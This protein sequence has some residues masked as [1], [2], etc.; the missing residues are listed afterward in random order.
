MKP[1]PSE[2]SLDPYEEILALIET[3]H[4][5][6]QRVEE[7]TAGQIDTVTNRTGQTFV[8]RPAQEHLRQI[9]AT[10]QAAI[11]NSLPA[12]VALLD[13]QGFIVSVND[14]WRA[15]ADANAVLTPRY[16]IGIS[17]LSVCDRA[18][19]DGSLLA[20]RAAAGIRSVLNGESKRYSVEY[21]CHSPDQERWFLMIVTPIA[22]KVPAGAVV[23][24]VDITERWK[25]TLELRE[26]ERRFSDF[27]QNVELL[28]V[29]LD[30]NARITF[31]NDYLLRLTGWLNEEVLG[32]SWFEVFSPPD[33]IQS[34]SA[35][36]TLLAGT[37]EV[38]HHES[39]ILTRSGD[40]RLIRWSNSALKS[41]SGEL[42]GTASIGEDVT[43]QRQASAE[44]L[45]SRQRLALATE[46][47]SLGIWDFDATT[48]TMAWDAQMLT[49]YGIGEQNADD[50]YDVWQ[51]GL[52]PE[53]R[54][55]VNADF[56]AALAGS[57]D[58][59]PQ[60]RVVWPNGEIR[61]LEARAVVQRSA[62]GVAT[63]MTG[64][65][66]DITERIRADRRIKQLNRVYA[67]L[68]G[69]NTL[70]VRVRTREELFEGACRI[71]VEQGEFR[72]ALLGILDADKTKIE[73]VAVVCADDELTTSITQLLSESH[74]AL[75]AMT[76]QAVEQKKP[77]VSNDSQHDSNVTG[78]DRHARFGVRSM[79]VLPVVVAGDAVGAMALYS[80]EL[81][82]F[83]AEELSLLTELAGDIAYAMDHVDKQDRLQYQAYY[84][85]LTGL[86]NRSMFLERVA[87]YTRD[88]SGDGN[89]VAVCLFDLE[90][91][92]N[93]NDDLGR[94]AGD[95][96]LIQVADWL[97]QSVRDA[98]VVARMDADRFAIA[99][100]RVPSKNLLV[101]ILQQ[102]REMFLLHPFHIDGGLFRIAF[103]GG[104]ALFPDDGTD[105][106][107]LLAHAEVALDKAKS[108]GEPY[109]FYEK[110]M[111]HAAAD[112]PTLEHQL[113]H[114]LDNGEF[115]LHY[116]PKVS[117]GTGKLTGVEGLIRWN[118]PEAGLIAP[119]R[120]IPILEETGLIH[121]VGQWVLNKAIDDF[122][123]W[124]RTGLTAVPIAV[125]ISPLQLRHRG[126]LELIQSSIAV[127]AG[128]AAGL[129]LEITESL[130]M[131]NV[132][133]SIESLH[134]IRAMG[135]RVA[136]DD[137]GT[138]FSSLSYLSRLPIDTL[139]ID[140]SFVNSMTTG[141]QGL[142]LVSTIVSLARSLSLKV[143]A[144]GVETDEEFRLLRLLGCDEMQGYLFSEPLPCEVLEERYLSK[145]AAAFTRLGAGT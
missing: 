91:F 99:L 14:A 120:F 61:N 143:V 90:R 42:I 118:D 135:V 97:R 27:L 138:G 96:V 82:F 109:L 8:L 18:R 76:A 26:S 38:W 131:E 5:T 121:H 133:H 94:H 124:Q 47:A 142:A 87:Q 129:E 110:Q 71:A 79:I 114:A 103:K 113:R 136:I 55:F 45:Q 68:S 78:G 98:G 59:D 132:N 12:H 126:F 35:I 123:R 64:V 25:S 70:I 107:M 128:A 134:A 102:Q 81:D 95:N 10:K 105:A 29:M 21:G 57:K 119:A 40:S 6:E 4:R 16:E 125:N 46:S 69:I 33:T 28:S 89:L 85:A 127:D 112:R 93:I 72:I 80:S 3:L 141:R 86:A 13:A 50:T 32:R 139:K 37:P 117:L 108:S 52:H 9:E 1:D 19:A 23:M 67:V 116:Q 140:R 58:F 62:D 73:P 7:L 144:E 17:Y 74:G 54:D 115:V 88:D 2:P 51:R 75:T 48:R 60:F 56:A 83:Q 77:V 20:G 130:I 44:V 137:F 31:C 100:P 30:T 11:L 101:S 106:E 65:N 66:W 145:H 43:E 41:G 104:I 15:F 53:D 122:L 84:D 92:K 49:L 111:T 22:D 39:K 34:N 63:R 36:A 24:H